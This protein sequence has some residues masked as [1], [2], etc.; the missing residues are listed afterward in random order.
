MGDVA[1]DAAPE[2]TP[3]DWDPDPWA[4]IHVRD[5]QTND[6]GWIVRRGGVE[7]VKLDRPEHDIVMPY[8]SRAWI[9]VVEHRMASRAQLAEVAFMA[10]R[11]LLRL[12]GMHGKARQEWVSLTEK[13][14]AAWIEEGPSEP[15]IR[16]FLYQAIVG[17][18]EEHMRSSNG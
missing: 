9:Q 17:V 7:S 16:R 13:Q 18:L 11:G 6:L 1:D 3:P 2:R 4:R 5:P 10:D 14:R 15:P 8:A 12:L